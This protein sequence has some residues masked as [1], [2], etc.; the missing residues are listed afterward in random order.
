VKGTAVDS[1]IAIVE[2]FPEHLSEAKALGEG[3]KVGGVDKIVVTGM[4]GSAIAGSLLQSYCSAKAPNL[5]VFVSRDYDLPGIV[6]GK[7]LVFAISYSGNT[8]E[9]LSSFKSA[10][11]KG[12]KIVVVTSGGKLRQ[13]AEQLNKQ[14]VL[15]PEGI[16]PR[17]ALPYLF[18]PLLNVLYNSGL[19]P[20][21]SE[22]IASTISS[23]KGGASG[24]FERA[25]SLADKLSGK[26]PLI[27]ASERMGG[28]AY[29]WK[30]QFN[31]NAKIHAFSH[32]F[33]E[34]NHNELVGYTKLN[35]NYYAIMLEDEA[36]NRRVKERVKLTKDIIGKKGVPSTQI[37]IK[38]E[39]PLTRILSAV[40]I[41]DLASVYLAKLT[42]VDPEPVEIIEDFKK[43]LGKVPF[44]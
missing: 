25:R 34:L 26:V 27:Y 16:Q 10:M 38:G 20:D 1:Y 33:P 39:Y 37:V 12:A 7:T 2:R 21:P 41:G 42:G 36:D 18:L 6:D 4:G 15:V 8:E 19:I 9:T 29:R 17:A 14:V 3:V 43:Q 23:L 13:Q 30:T 35:A 40:Y 22:E 44:V 11:R 32:V 28:V 5:P 31:E 24:Y